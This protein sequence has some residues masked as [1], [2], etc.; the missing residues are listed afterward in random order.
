M[1]E[2]HALQVL[3]T[4]SWNKRLNIM[5]Y[6]CVF[7]WYFKSPVMKIGE[8]SSNIGGNGDFFKGM[9]FPLSSTI[10]LGMRVACYGC[11]KGG[12]GALMVYWTGQVTMEKVLE[13]VMA[14]L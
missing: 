4:Q 8:D 9:L 2:E 1:E 13:C 5:I 6:V 14:L 10:G 7:L 12:L 3:S 11:G